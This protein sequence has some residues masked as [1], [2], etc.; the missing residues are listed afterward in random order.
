MDTKRIAAMII[1][2]ASVVSACSSGDT[3]AAV[4]LEARWQCDV[5]RQTFSD[6]TALNAALD[7]RLS[8]ADLSRGDYES[9]KEDLESS[10]SLRTQVAQEYEAYCLQ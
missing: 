9:F 10:A 2:V 7:E 3:T 6:L 8:A 1:A 5:Q 4:T